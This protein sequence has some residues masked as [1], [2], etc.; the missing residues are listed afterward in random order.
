[1]ATPT[2]HRNQSSSL[3]HKSVEWFQYKKNIDMKKASSNDI[4]LRLKVSATT[5]VQGSVE[6]CTEVIVMSLNKQLMAAAYK[7]TINSNNK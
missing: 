7:C 6:C 4:S 5:S 2:P 3:Q 1:M